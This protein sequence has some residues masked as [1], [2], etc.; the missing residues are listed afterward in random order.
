MRAVLLAAVPGLVAGV[1]VL[2]VASKAALQL[3]VGVG[4]LVAV[5]LQVRRRAEGAGTTAWWPVI[6]VG[7]TAGVLTTT[8]GTSGPPL[9]LWLEH[10]RA[11]PGQTRDTLAAMFIGLNLMG[12]AAIAV[13]GQADQAFRPGTVGVL[14]A[15]AVTGHAAGRLLFHRLDAR[16]FR[17]AGLSLCALAGLASIAAAVA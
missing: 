13:L 3:A 14:L 17:L 8:T 6:G 12:A 9:V 4:V 7:A 1:L 10:R 11:T 15:V 2:T 5:L 16:Q